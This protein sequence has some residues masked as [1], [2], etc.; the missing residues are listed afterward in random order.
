MQALPSAGKGGNQRNG[1]APLDPGIGQMRGY[2]LGATE[3]HG[4]HQEK[5]LLWRTHQSVPDVDLANC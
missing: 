4:T 5:D 2:A 1:I 3:P